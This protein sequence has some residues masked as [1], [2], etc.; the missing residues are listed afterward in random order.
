[1]INFS[2]MRRSDQEAFL[3]Y[4]IVKVL[5]QLGGKSS[6][7]ALRRAVVIRTDS[8]D[9]DVLNE[10]KVSKKGNLYCPFNFPFNFALKNLELA[11]YITR[12]Q[13]GFIQLAEKGRT[14]QGEKN[15]FAEKVYEVSR[16]YWD[17]KE[18]HNSSDEFEENSSE[19]ESWRLRLLNALNNL[20]PQKFELFCRALMQQLNIEIDEKLGMSPVGDGGID[21][22][23]YLTS[24]DLRTTRVA[25][26][27][28]KWGKNNSVSSPEIDKFRGAMDKFRAEY[29]IFITTSSFTRSA[30]EAARRGTHVITL[31]DGEQLVDLVAKYR[32]YVHPVTTYELDDFF[33]E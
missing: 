12:P 2:E 5:Q 23:G 20:S 3:M 8:I 14:F 19:E 17:K 32:L 30:V 25:L 13:R 1:M 29:G 26:Q 18:K 11:G 21:G 27:A 16:P 6:T 31:I 24:D 28:K 10:R 4:P 33:L 22:Y 7:Q 15:G 9:E